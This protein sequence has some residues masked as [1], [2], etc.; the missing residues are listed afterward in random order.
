MSDVS[1]S[2][3]RKLPSNK[4]IVLLG[5]SSVNFLLSFGVYFLY[6]LRLIKSLFSGYDGSGKTTLIS[7]LRGKE[8]E[9]SKG[10]GLEYTYLDVHDEERDGM[11]L[12][13]HLSRR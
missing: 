5:S 1:S 3:S 10:H 13:K 11:K 12:L 4:S 7:K 8:D 9:I 2:A 6:L